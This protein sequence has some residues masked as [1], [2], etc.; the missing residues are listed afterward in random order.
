MEKVV[1]RKGILVLGHGSRRA[2]A[3]ELVTGLVDR[4]REDLNS[5]L[6]EPA[7]VQ[8]AMPDIPTGLAKLIGKGCRQ[9]VVLALF[10][11]NGNH[12]VK[13]VPFLLRDALAQQDGVSFTLTPPL[14]HSP[15]MYSLILGC[16]QREVKPNGKATPEL[17]A[18]SSIERES[19]EIVDT[20]LVGLTFAEGERQV[21][22]RVVH[23]TA[24]P[25][26]ARSLLFHPRAVAAA[27]TALR[28]GV[29]ILVDAN[30][31]AAGIDRRRLHQLG[32]KVVCSLAYPGMAKRAR[33]MGFTRSQ[34]AMRQMLGEH[35][36]GVVVVGNAPTALL[37]VVE[38][39]ASGRG[40][41]PPVVIGV[42]VGFVA[43]AEAKERLANSGVPFIANRGPR[44]GS[45]VAVS[46][47]N[48]LLRLSEA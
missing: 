12:L 46:I 45:S 13:D 16:L 41:P 17:L 19:F 21:V 30:M 47:V 20:H 43:A 40:T 35:P 7:F 29:N 4:L 34:A 6:V 39:V 26:F 25:L 33:D 1:N 24:D 23:A 28:Q 31:V 2:E 48:A 5:D 15:E 3:G 27:V 14:L 36:G 18:S 32:G 44:G 22:R 8:L 38:A 10:L 11:V 9:I 42:P 37:E